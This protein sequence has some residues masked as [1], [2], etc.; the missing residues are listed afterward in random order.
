MQLTE[1]LWAV[2]GVAALVAELA[3]LKGEAGMLPL[4]T[5]LRDKLFAKHAI[6]RLAVYLFFAWMGGHFFLHI[7]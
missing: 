3:G 7:A 2:I 4:T 1:I 5:V 6:L